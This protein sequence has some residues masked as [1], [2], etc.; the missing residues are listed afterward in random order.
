M[1]R[2]TELQPQIPVWAKA[3]HMEI[4]TPQKELWKYVDEPNRMTT[5]RRKGNI[6]KK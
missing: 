6:R 3:E 2:L 5:R 1:L 4:C